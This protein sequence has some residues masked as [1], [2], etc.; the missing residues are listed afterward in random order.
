LGR[1]AFPRYGCLSEPENPAP[2]G[3]AP[4]LGIAFKSAKRVEMFTKSSKPLTRYFPEI[5]AA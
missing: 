3:G 1:K 5:A 2:D 4:D